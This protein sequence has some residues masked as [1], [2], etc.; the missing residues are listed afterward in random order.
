MNKLL[1]VSLFSFLIFYGCNQDTDVNSSN[2]DDNRSY[3]LIKL[4]PRAGLSVETTFSET[5]TIDGDKGGTIKI[6]ESYVA[7]NGQ[8]VKIDGKLKVKKHSFNGIV[9]ITMTIDD[10]FAAVSFTPPMVFSIPAEL[11]LKFEGIELENLHVLTGEYEFV[12]ISDTWD[13]EPVNYNSMRVDET[14]GKLSVNKADINH[15]SRFGWVR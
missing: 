8:T 15:F 9:D 3:Q 14:W 7:T 6:K 1:I 4:P 13:I 11:K 2:Q 12:Y 5:K 10:E